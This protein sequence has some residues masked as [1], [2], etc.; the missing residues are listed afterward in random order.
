MGDEIPAA[1]RERWRRQ[2]KREAAAVLAN[3]SHA[4]ADGHYVRFHAHSPIY[5]RAIREA[6]ELLRGRN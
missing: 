1:L 4:N 3:C 5:D 2:L 6:E